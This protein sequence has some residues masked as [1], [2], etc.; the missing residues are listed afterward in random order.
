MNSCLRTLFHFRWPKKLDVFIVR[1]RLCFPPLLSELIQ[2]RRLC[3]IKIALRPSFLKN[4]N[5]NGVD[6]KV[7]STG[8]K[9]DRV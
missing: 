4:K 7:I 3:V 5:K 8:S 6:Q 2:H 1:Q 9:I